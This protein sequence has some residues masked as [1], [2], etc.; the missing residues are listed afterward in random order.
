MSEEII[1][2]IPTDKRKA[3][4][5]ESEVWAEI[6]EKVASFVVTDAATAAFAHDMAKQARA[7]YREKEEERKTIT[8][9]LLQAKNATDAYFKPTLE[10]VARI[11]RHYE[12][13][14]ATYDLEREQ[15]R[16]KVLI[17]SAAEL[18]VGVVPTEPIPEPVY[19]EQTSVRHVWEP[20][21]VDPDLVPRELCSPDLRK[22]REAVWYANTPHKPPHPVPGVKF[23]LKSIVVVR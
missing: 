2:W 18:A 15:A 16:A 10:A 14:I 20:E 3:L 23:A 5:K 7:I 13:A 4:V 1:T 17:Q 8:T 19:V 11:K 21:I 12:Q 9:P 22:I 6:A